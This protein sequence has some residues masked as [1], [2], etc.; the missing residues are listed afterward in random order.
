MLDGRGEAGELRRANRA[1]EQRQP[2]SAGAGRPA[3]RPP[4]R[5]VRR[6]RVVRRRRLVALAGAAVV[7]FVLTHGGLPGSARSFASPRRAALAG[8]TVRQ[9]IVA[10]ADSQ[11]GYGTDP[12]GSYCNKFS[13]YW[14]SGSQGCPGGEA[15]EEWCADFAAWVW[16]KA[17]VHLAYGYSPG[18]L[19]A[20]AVSFYEW[21]VAHGTWHPASSGY[22]PAAGDVVV[23]GLRLGAVPWAAHVAIVTGDPARRRGP[24]VI[25]GDGDR[26]GFSVVETG[27]DELRADTGHRRGALLAG[28]VSP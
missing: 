16:Q 2:R 24:D 21:G 6:Q 4:A 5:S 9:R 10:I 13:A 7:V 27:T 17:G 15:S 28:Y 19:N 14:G 25:N 22:R 12:S 1:R 3:R 26:E 23:Y 11:V 8:L 18:E 20:G